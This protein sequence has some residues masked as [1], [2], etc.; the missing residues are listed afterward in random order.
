MKRTNLLLAA[1]VIAVTIFGAQQTMAQGKTGSARWSDYFGYSRC[2]VL[3]NDSAR[4]ILCPQCGG[5][6][7]EYSWKGKNALHLDSTQKGWVR[8]EGEKV[9]PCGGRFDI[10]P[11]RVIPPH[12]DLWLGAW[13]GEIVGSN[14][15]RLTSVADP[16]TGTQLVREFTLDPSTSHLTCK[17]VIK[18]ISDKP[19]EWCHWSRTLAEGDGICLIPLT[20]NSRFPKKYVMYGLG[21]VINYQPEDPNI[22]VRDGF[23]EV[24]ATP[25]RPKLGIDSYAGWFCYLLK[26]D[27]MLVKRY[28][29]YRDRVYNEVAGLT[30]SIWYFENQMCELEPIGPRETLA[31]CQSAS[32]TEEWWLLPYAFPANRTEVNL[33]EVSEMVEKQAR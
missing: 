11:E 15:A 28:P 18:N 21:P 25:E 3:E 5:R 22:R 10:G 1:G 19:T 7:L 13:S 12:P 29:T 26:N 2:I 31:P 24:M 6:V 32:F 17:Q 16:A 30:I 20:D 9:D 33:K 27:L 23:L 8:T 14:M 4:V